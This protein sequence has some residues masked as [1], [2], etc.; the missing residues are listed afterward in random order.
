M[1][2]IL[3]S[4]LHNG[5]IAI[6]WTYAVNLPYLPLPPFLSLSHV[7]AHVLIQPRSHSLTHL[8]DCNAQDGN[9][10]D[11]VGLPPWANGSPDEFVRIQ[12]EALE[13]EYVSERL[14]G[15]L[16]LIFGVQQRGSKAKEAVN[17]FYYLTYEGAADLDDISDPMQRKV[18]SEYQIQAKWLCENT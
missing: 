3:D 1:H 11:N 6:S 2:I 10:L 13:G 15:W 17:V 4:S 9:Q 18:R 16:D 5:C 7:Y 8:L 14:H 12:R